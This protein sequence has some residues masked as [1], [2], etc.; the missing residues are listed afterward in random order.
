MSD[1]GIMVMRNKKNPYLFEKHS[2]M[3]TDEMT[4][5]SDIHFKN[6]EMEAESLD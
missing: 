3:F 2:E 6:N 1:N 5:K 4:R